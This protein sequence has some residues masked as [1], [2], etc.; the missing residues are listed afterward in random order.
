MGGGGVQKAGGNLGIMMTLFTK[1]C[2]FKNLA[3]DMVATFSYE[4]K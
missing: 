1:T 4:K 3:F 2:H